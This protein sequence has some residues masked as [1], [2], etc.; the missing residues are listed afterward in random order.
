MK[1]K[2]ELAGLAIVAL[3]VGGC[4]S[5]GSSSSVS[6]VTLI[7]A[8]SEVPEE[9]L[10]DVTIEVFDPGLL[11]PSV[12]VAKAEKAG[13]FP[14]VRKAEAR[15]IPYQLKQT[16]QSTGNWGAVR[17][18][19]EGTSSAEV[20]VSGGV[21][22][23]TGKD[24]VVEVQ[25]RDAA[26][27]VWLEKRYKQE[28]DVLVYSPEQVKRKDPFHALYSAI[29]NDMLVERQKRKQS[30]L[31]KLRNIADLRFAADLA[32]VAFEDYLSL[33]R[34]ERYHLE[35]LPAEDD[36]MMQRIAEIRER[37]YT[38]VDTLNEYYATF[39]T[40]MEEPYNN[41]R[42]FSYEEQLALEKLRRQARMQKIV[43]ALAIFG[44]V[45]AP[46]GGSSAGRVARDVAVIGGVAAIQS[47]M[48]K[49]QEAKI[50][51]EALR[52]LGGSLDV[53]V[54]P[55]VVEVEGETLRLS[56]T[57]EGQFAEW[58]E[59]LRRIY[60]EETGLP[61]DPNVEAGQSARSSV[62]N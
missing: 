53:E 50:H 40:S 27:E 16:L 46:T 3:A 19:P 6:T 10:L 56:G 48:A 58:R 42:S 41:W 43:G 52:E 36:S 47:G 17:V 57:M 18:M 7:Q 13:V 31:M 12:P 55:L 33:D 23:S 45:V 62:E 11:D 51:V 14:E 9:A 44:A 15:F 32:P 39:S 5:T 4:A 28:A 30:E 59:M 25:V 37:D 20:T 8:V 61:T 54:A 24:L 35:H 34:K 2:R 1:L 49:S 21:I 29:A 26:G 60:S 22:K 38:F